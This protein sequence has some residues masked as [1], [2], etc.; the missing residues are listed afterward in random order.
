MSASAL[1]ERLRSLWADFRRFK[2]RHLTV[3][4]LWHSLI[5]L[6]A[7]VF[8]CSMFAWV[9]ELSTDQ[10]W[11]VLYALVILV[12]FL[13]WFLFRLWRKR[14]ALPIAGIIA[15]LAIL[16]AVEVPLLD[17]D[18]ARTIAALP[19][20]SEPAILAIDTYDI[21]DFTEKCGD[22]C[23]EILAKSR[24]DVRMGDRLYRVVAGDQ[25]RSGA[26]RASYFEFLSLGFSGICARQFQADSAQSSQG[27]L[28]VIV[29]HCSNRPLYDAAACADLPSRFRGTIVTVT[30]S[31]GGSPPRMVRR[32]LEGVIEPHNYWYAFLGLEDRTVGPRLSYSERLSRALNLELQGCCVPGRD[33]LDQ[34]LTQL[35]GFLDD[36]NFAAKAWVV[37]DPVAR[38]RGSED[39]SIVNRHIA[40]EL[41]K[42]SSPHRLAGLNMIIA[43]RT[44]DVA[45]FR[46]SVE[47]LRQDPDKLVAEF[48]KRAQR[49]INGRMPGDPD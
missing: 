1:L 5:A 11:I 49:R 31:G 29:D 6:G 16:Y 48:A 7:I 44:T 23:L 47:A 43:S 17:R 22:L 36:P 8:F 2:S 26:L 33:D 20:V 13:I 21:S 46:S 14:G 19:P 42:Q 35:D 10:G 38:V 39:P 28:R 4:F 12:P 15:A 40:L 45:P 32:W 9:G 41:A 27:L 18:V 3:Q 30:E 37:F 24:A 34:V 25:C